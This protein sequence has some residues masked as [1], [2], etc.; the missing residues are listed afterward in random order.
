[1][2]RKT[3]DLK[4]LFFRS[5]TLWL[6]TSLLVIGCLSG[7]QPSSSTSQAA[8]EQTKLSPTSSLTPSSPF[9]LARI[10]EKEQIKTLMAYDH[11]QQLRQLKDFNGKVVALFFGYTHCPDVCPTTLGDF[12]YIMKQLS[13]EEQKD[14]QV[15]FM[16]VDPERDTPDLLKQYVPSF[17]P[18]FLGFYTTPEKTAVIAKDFKI[19]YQKSKNASQSTYTI[20]HTAGGY[21][22]DKKGRLRLHFEHAQDPELIL[23]DLRILLKEA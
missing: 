21:I 20:D 16:T 14:F 13:P 1:M 18:S 9:K 3:S 17:Y 11:H 15:I 7:C 23:H 5:S 4:K 2:G 6:S 10:P 8:A 19:F 22:L 12:S